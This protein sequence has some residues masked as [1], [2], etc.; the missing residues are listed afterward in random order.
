MTIQPI[1]MN[2]GIAATKGTG[3]PAKAGAWEEFA[4]LLSDQIKQT[5]QLQNEA[6]DLSEKAMLGNAGVSL[7]EAQIASAKADLHMRLLIQ[8]R[9][10]A[11]EA[12]REVMRMPA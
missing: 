12:Y 9:N 7:H 2:L 8:V 4:E 5:D 1:D 6:V 11:V 10:K 3:G